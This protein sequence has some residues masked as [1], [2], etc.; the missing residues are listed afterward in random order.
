MGKRLVLAIVFVGVLVMTSCTGF[1]SD[2]GSGPSPSDTVSDFLEYMR[3]GEFEEAQ[4]FLAE[5]S[6]F[7][8]HEIEEEFRSIFKKLEVDEMTA[9]IN[10]DESFVVFEIETVD[11]ATV[12]EEVINENFYLVFTDITTDVLSSRIQETMLQKMTSYDVPMISAEAT[13]AL[14]LQDNEWKIVSDDVFVDALTGGLISFM[15]YMQ[16]IVVQ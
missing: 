4:K 9:V 5:E 1:F 7:L 11:F 15:D 8:I 16:S 14:I 13:A 3:A 6:S 2:F 10:G 12:M